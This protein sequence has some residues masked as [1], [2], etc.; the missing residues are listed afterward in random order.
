MNK[1]DRLYC[2]LVSLNQLHDVVKALHKLYEDNEE[3][4]DD[5]DISS[6]VPMSLDEW[7]YKLGRVIGAIDIECSKAVK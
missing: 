4:N 5:A 2:L 6:I 7:N 1:H 3:L